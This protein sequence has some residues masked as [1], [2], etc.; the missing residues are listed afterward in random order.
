MNGQLVGLDSLL[1]AGCFNEV[2]SQGCGFLP[3]E[4]P[5]DHITAEDVEDHIEVVV[6]SFDRT[7]ELGDIP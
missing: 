5:A 7:E 1:V 2:L 6:G 3:C 4:H